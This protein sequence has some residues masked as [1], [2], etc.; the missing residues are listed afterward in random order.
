MIHFLLPRLNN[1]LYKY[2]DHNSSDL[3]PQ[4]VISNSLSYYLYDIKSRINEHEMDWNTYKKYTNPF[5]YI[6]TIV[7]HK[8]KCIS[9]LKPLS[10][11]YFKMVE[12]ITFF[13]LGLETAYP[14]N[15]FHLAE[16]PG[17]F[18]EA[19]AALRKR[20]DDKY[21]GMTILADYNDPNI[22]AWKKSTH[23]LREHPNVE[24]ETGTD[25]TGNILSV[26]NFEYCYKK[27]SSSMEIIT[28]DGGFDFTADFN[29]QEI[30]IAKLL[31]GQVIY[32]LCMQKYKGH[33]ILK[34]F[35]IFMQHT[36]DI[37]AI[38]SSFYEHVYITKPQTSRYANSEKYIVCR[39]F[40]FNANTKFY[41][42]LY[43]AFSHMLMETESP[44]IMYDLRFLSVSIP[45]SFITKLEEYNAV[46]G[47]HQIENIH[48]TLLLIENKYKND[49]IESLVKTHVQ[50][51][52]VWC[53]KH[54]IP[55]NII[56]ETVNIFLPQ[57]PSHYFTTI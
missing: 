55:Y 5:E 3:I 4:S 21:I 11:S 26:A 6:N 2:I 19:I 27:Y 49:K 12:I 54:N 44:K 33:F 56:E 32:A 9:K 13:K 50:K 7:P 37:L 30:N 39:G 45:R 24:I 53:T 47:Q 23:F 34:I 48:F 51:C 16:G 40:L 57:R 10:R 43:N 52:M 25:K 31:F 1:D 36:V 20:D 18:I 22:P 42:T 41:P 46:F 17:G 35:D 15:T 28:A 14:L 29:S 38:L 8:R